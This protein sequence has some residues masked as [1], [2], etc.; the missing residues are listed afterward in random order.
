M[1][2]ISTQA[3]IGQLC[4]P[5][6][7]VLSFH[8]GLVALSLPLSLSVSLS[9]LVS[10][11]F[12]PSLHLFWPLSIPLSHSFYFSLIHLCLHFLIYPYSPPCL[13]HYSHTSLLALPQ[14]F[15]IHAHV[16]GPRCMP[17]LPPHFIPVSPQMSA[18]HRGLLWP[19]NIITPYPLCFLTAPTTS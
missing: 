4:V 16:K 11:G 5:P 1:G 18:L 2:D 15:Q 12:P 10:Q 3:P 7:K 19:P 13:P 14:T 9:L 17:T 6:S 8:G